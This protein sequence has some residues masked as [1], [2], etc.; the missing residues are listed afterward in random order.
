ME[1]NIKINDIVY[2]KNFRVF[3]K[4]RTLEEHRGY[5]KVTQINQLTHKHWLIGNVVTVNDDSPQTK[6]LMKIKYG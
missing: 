1:H 3:G 5:C 2:H 6:L 4:V